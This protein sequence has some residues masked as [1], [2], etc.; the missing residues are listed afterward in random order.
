M[1][2]RMSV[3]VL[4]LVFLLITVSISAAGKGYRLNTAAQDM[5][6]D[7]PA[8][9]GQNMREDRPVQA[10]QARLNAGTVDCPNDG[11]CPYA[12]SDSTQPAAQQ[13]GAARQM[14]MRQ[15]R[16]SGRGWR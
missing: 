8:L 1:S 13:A 9:Y 16:S 15:G 2:R 5:T 4:V 11:I 12:G 14:A 6:A 10:V 3:M 7:R